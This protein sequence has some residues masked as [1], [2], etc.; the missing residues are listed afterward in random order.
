MHNTGMHQVRE[1]IRARHGYIFPHHCARR[2]WRYGVRDACAERDVPAN[3]LSRL[4]INY[5]DNV[6]T[7]CDMNKHEEVKDGTL[8]RWGHFKNCGFEGGGEVIK[9]VYVGGGNEYLISNEYNKT[10]RHL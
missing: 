10:K 4:Y 2:S 5:V 1:V 3:H 9:I 6:G 7:Q 8:S